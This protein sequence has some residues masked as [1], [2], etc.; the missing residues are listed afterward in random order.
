[1]RVDVEPEAVDEG[2][3]CKGRKLM[4][5]ASSKVAV[6]VEKMLL[7]LLDVPLRSHVIFDAE[8]D[9]AEMDLMEEVEKQNPGV[10]TDSNSFARHFNTLYDRYKAYVGGY[11]AVDTR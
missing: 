3:G 1:M 6:V 5:N 10:M 8:T 7:P 4:H 9:Q 2:G 11:T